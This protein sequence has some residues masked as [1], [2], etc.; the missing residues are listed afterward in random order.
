MRI[1]VV[2][3]PNLNLL[4]RREPE[5]YGP[6]TLTEIDARIAERAGR[7]G[8]EVDLF[9]SNHEGTFVEKIHE[10]HN[11]GIDAIVINAGAWTHY[12]Y[13]I[14]DALAMLKIPVVEAHLSNIHARESF[15]HQSLIAPLAKGQISG[16]GVNSYLLS[17]RAAYH[18]IKEK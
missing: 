18:L 1:L 9:Q 4:G 10:A 11:T 7:L 2:H 15:R 8:V 5:I 6:A 13:A 16:F 12:N 3:G 14:H 17:L